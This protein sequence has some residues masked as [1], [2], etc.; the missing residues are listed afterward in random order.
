MRVLLISLLPNSHRNLS[1]LALYAV[2]DARGHD[3]ALLFIPNRTVYSELHLSNFLSENQYDVVGLSVMTSDFY[4]AQNITQTIYKHLPRSRIIW[5]GIHPTCLPEES[6]GAV[7]YICRGEGDKVFINWLNS[8]DKDESVCDLPGLG[9]KKSDGSIQLNNLFPLIENLDDIPWNRYDWDNYY[10]LDEQGV[11]RFGINDYIRYSR[12]NGDGY[13][14]MTSRSCP[15][16]CTYCINSFIKK[17]YHSNGVVRRRSVNHVIAELKHAMES[18]QTVRF[19]NFI[20]DHF[21]T[22]SRWTQEFCEK[23][24][25][26]IGLPFIIRASP[27]ALTNQNMKMLKHAGLVTIQTGI[28]SGSERTHKLIFN[29]PFNRE[30]ILKASNELKQLAILPIYDVIIE[31]D[32]EN[33]DDRDATLRLL[34]ELNRPYELNLFILTPLPKTDII[35]KYETLGIH[36]RIDPYVGGYLDYNE[37]NYYYQMA[38]IIPYVPLRIGRYLYRHRDNLARLLLKYLYKI[39]KKRLRN[40]SKNI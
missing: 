17:L 30:A 22:S 38:S 21:L 9:I 34:L 32:F 26:V 28:Q 4:F 40:V 14:T 39:I 36:S 24:R 2:A 15:F 27:E 37:S 29:R 16:N 6:L 5:G 25:S 23:Y 31:N 7:D 1:C 10:L 19:I 20:D 18:I 12:H 13:T 11:H 35:D 33:D 8:L 3:T